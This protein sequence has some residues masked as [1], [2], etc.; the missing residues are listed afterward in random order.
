MGPI[1]VFRVSTPILNLT[2]LGA[3]LEVAGEQ[4]GR[5]SVGQGAT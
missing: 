4:R 5:H 1:A 2:Y 3:A